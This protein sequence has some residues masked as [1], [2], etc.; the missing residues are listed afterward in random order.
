[1]LMH[2]ARGLISLQHIL[3]RASWG[4]PVD[5]SCNSA[6]KSVHWQ[7]GLLWGK[8]LPDAAGLAQLKPLIICLA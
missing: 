1:V 4:N 5:S 7:G 3:P 2:H 6:F 8:P